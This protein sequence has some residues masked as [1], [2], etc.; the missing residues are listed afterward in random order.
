MKYLRKHSNLKEGFERFAVWDTN[1]AILLNNRE[2]LIWYKDDFQLE[3]S[4]IEL[5]G[6]KVGCDMVEAMVVNSYLKARALILTRRSLETTPNE[7]GRM[8]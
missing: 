8:I 5:S 4:D 6:W 2:L 3:V 1:Y 7:G